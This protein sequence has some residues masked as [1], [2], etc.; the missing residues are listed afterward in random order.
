MAHPKGVLLERAQKLGLERPEFRTARTGPEHEP[1]F[2]TD[3]VLEGEVIGT[4]QGGSKRT[5]EKNAA[6][7][8]LAA[9]EA[10]LEATDKPAAKGKGK[11][12]AAKDG[13]AKAAAAAQGGGAKA[14]RSSGARGGK[15]GAAAGG[16]K[17]GG[18]EPSA[19][20]ARAGAAVTTPAAAQSTAAAQ[21]APAAVEDDVEEEPFDGPWPMFDDLLA[22]VVTVAERRVFA[23]LRGEDARVA[24]RDFSLDLYKEL[25]LGLGEI[26][27]EEED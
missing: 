2:I 6:E 16:G 5:A 27:E 8:A 10:R 19:A 13:G 18:A 7:E 14:T 9:L 3:V 1:V 17:D 15:A 4:G 23:D 20:S 24:I 11:Q 25:L 26:E 22:A 12:A 21:P